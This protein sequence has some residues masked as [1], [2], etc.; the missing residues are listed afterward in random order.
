[1]HAQANVCTQMSTDTYTSPAPH[2]QIMPS[3]PLISTWVSQILRQ[4]QVSIKTA[5]K[6][7]LEQPNP[8]TCGFEM[9]K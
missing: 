6:T 1:M 9:E 2:V 8:Q 7:V 4:K 5:S 3:D